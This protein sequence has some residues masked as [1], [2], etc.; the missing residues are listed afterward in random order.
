MPKS[1]IAIINRE[2]RELSSCSSELSRP[3]LWLNEPAPNLNSCLEQLP[4]LIKKLRQ[5]INNTVQE[6]EDQKTAF[7][8]CLLV[9]HQSSSAIAQK[10]NN[11]NLKGVIL[12]YFWIDFRTCHILLKNIYTLRS[13]ADNL[14]EHL[15]FKRLNNNNP[16]TIKLNN[17]IAQ[18]HRL[19]VQIY[20]SPYAINNRGHRN[21]LRIK[22]LLPQSSA[23]T[24]FKQSDKDEGNK[25]KKAKTQQVVQSGSPHPNAA[26]PH[27]DPS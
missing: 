20:P 13:C 12:S 17:N 3:S 15:S 5:I 23:A 16:G 25:A 8:S 1:K 11:D 19:L 2:I 6:Y 4:A 24:T 10:L 14:K 26:Q 22:R 7:L 27:F 9:K 21:I 18:L